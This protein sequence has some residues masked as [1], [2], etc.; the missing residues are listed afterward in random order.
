[1]TRVPTH[2]AMIM[3]GN[4]RWAV[5]RGKPRLAGH[6]AGAKTV[7]RVIGW[8][9]EVGVRY[10]TLYAFSTENWK[11][12]AEEVDGLMKLMGLLLRTRTAAFVEGNV[13][14]RLVGRR[15]DLPAAL[16]R[17]IADAERQTAAC[18]G[19]QV[20]LAV[21]YGGRAEIADAAR[22]YA[23]DVA[24]GRVDAS[25]PPSDDVFRRYLYAPDVPD[26]DL[27]VRTSGEWRLSNFLLWQSAYAELWVTPVLWPDFARADFDAALV[28]YAGRARRMGGRPA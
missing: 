20:L 8:C 15:H 16:Q 28:A 2:V 11:R 4:G 17:K 25:V 24:A 6:R 27:V 14:I 26:P 23:E 3:D 7:E 21:S 19:L 9:R 18:D 5:A 13:R 10:L 22:R 1:M 12:S